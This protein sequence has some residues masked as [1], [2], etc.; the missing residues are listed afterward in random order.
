MIN[1]MENTEVVKRGI[2]KYGNSKTYGVKIC[3]SHIFYGTGD[4]ADPVEIQKDINIECYYV[5][6]E[7]LLRDNE[8]NVGGGGFLTVEEAVASIESK[9]SVSWLD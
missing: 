8:F 5:F 7:N 6:Y 3:K 2:C 9:Y 4:V 1:N